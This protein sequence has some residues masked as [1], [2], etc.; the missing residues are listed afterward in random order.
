MRKPILCLDFDGVCHAYTSGWQGAAVIPDDAV[1]GL[2]EFLE[3]AAPHFDIQVFSSRSNLPGG[4]KAM[5]AWFSTQQRKWQESR[6]RDEMQ[7]PL[8]FPAKKPPATVSL[9]DR[10]LTFNGQ[11]PQIAQLQAFQPWYRTQS[12]PAEAVV[13][14]YLAA[15]FAERIEHVAIRDLLADDFTFQGPLMTADSADDYIQ[16]LQAF[17]EDA[18]MQADI[19][20]MWETETAVVVRY[21]FLIPSGKVPA[22]EWYQVQDG[23]ITNIQLICDPRP[24]LE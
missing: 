5:K 13:T 19:H 23:K 10:A 2:F 24:F 12:L 20:G 6:G 22:S 18:A 17:G 15:F 3:E 8:T 11:W 14:Q 7:L 16:K 1:P 4:I 21:D 9:D